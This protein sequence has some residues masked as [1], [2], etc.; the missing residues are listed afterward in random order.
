MLV[1]PLTR[2]L[3]RA[4]RQC[5]DEHGTIAARMLTCDAIRVLRRFEK[6]DRRL[7][8]FDRRRHRER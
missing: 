4:Y 8:L 2:A 1:T 5:R 7:R 6:P 3:L